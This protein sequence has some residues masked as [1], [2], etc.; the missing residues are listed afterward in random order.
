MRQGKNRGEYE[1]NTWE[2]PLKKGKK[3]FLWDVQKKTQMKTKISEDE[4]KV[5]KVKKICEIVQTVHRQQSEDDD[6]TL[7]K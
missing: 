2:E 7:I 1:I 3:H 6:T 5:R 4:R